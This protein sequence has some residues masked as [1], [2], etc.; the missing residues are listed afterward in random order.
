MNRW[1][2]VVAALGAAGTALAAEKTE[3][4]I[5][6]GPTA[7]TAEE[8]AIV[9]DPAAGMQH[10]VILVEETDR[11]E[12]RGTGYVLSYHLR[13]KILSSEGRALADVEIPVERPSELRKWWGRTILPDGKVLELTDREL[14]AQTVA[15][16]SLVQKVTM[17]GAL[18]GVVPGAVIDYGYIIR[19]EGY[20]PFTRVELEQEWP[21]RTF[22]FRWVPSNHMPAAFTSTHIEGRNVVVTPNSTSV[23]VTASNLKAVKEEPYMPPEGEVRAAVTLYYGDSSEK[24]DVFWDLE[25]KRAET[26]LKSFGSAA[27]MREAIAQMGIPV[28]APLPA[29]LAAAYDWIGANMTNKYFKTAE[30]ADAVVED[31]EDQA[32]TAKAVLKAKEG[33]GRQLDYLFAGVARGLGA[34]AALIYS[35][36]RTDRY[37]NRGWKSLDQFDYTF[38][39]VRA[40]GDAED[41]PWTVVDAGSGLPYGEVPWNATGSTAFVC[42]PKGMKSFVIPPAAGPKNRTDTHV[43]IGFSEDDEITAKWSRL[44]LGAAGMDSRRWLRR[45]DPAERKEKLDRLCG[46]RGSGEVAAAELPNLDQPAAPFQIACDIT[47]GEANVGEDISEYHLTA[48]GPWWPETPELTAA[49]RIHPVVF[50]YPRLDIVSVDIVPP[51]GFSAKAPPQPVKVESPFGKYQ[52]AATKTEKGFHVD[53]A[54][55]LLPLFVKPTDYD[56]LKAFLRQVHTADQTALVFERTGGT[57]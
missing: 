50:E 23:L 13:A 18:P 32:N 46:G 43:T 25:A 2:I 21:V 54:F 30:E 47:A 34:E 39:G 24:L 3:I 28:D 51:A 16:T 20:F 31:D 10:A 19:G 35:V 55:A 22:R 48:M 29:R 52:W 17:K 12:S 1:A 6:P 37:W 57:P 7:I 40:P 4:V 33:T 11:D 42:T 26:R 15:K 9:A 41:A 27:V 8:A 38:V 45:L 56:A 49:T 44:G 53:R 36:D 14:S 5:G